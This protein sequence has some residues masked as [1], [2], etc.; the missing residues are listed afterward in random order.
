MGWQRRKNLANYITYKELGLKSRK[1][2]G[3]GGMARRLEN[4]L[5]IVHEQ[6]TTI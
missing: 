4:S 2:D 1:G 3:H 5:Y 6:W